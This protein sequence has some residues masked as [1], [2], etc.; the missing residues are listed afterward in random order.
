MRET[1]GAVELP[2]VRTLRSAGSSEKDS[3][4]DEVSTNVVCGWHALL[5]T[6]VWIESE[7]LK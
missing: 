4:S 6:A 5:Y 1:T 7:L 2:P 3:G